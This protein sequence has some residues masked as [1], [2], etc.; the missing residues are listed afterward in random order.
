MD[1]VKGGFLNVP[2]LRSQFF[3]F[4]FDDNSVKKVLKDSRIKEIGPLE[5]KRE[6]VGRFD[7][8]G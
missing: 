7:L 3:F 1:L 2:L 6:S 5:L 8:A 4:L